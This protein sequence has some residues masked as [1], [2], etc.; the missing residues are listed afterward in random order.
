[1]SAVDI[2]PISDHFIFE[3]L[4]DTHEIMAANHNRNFTIFSVLK[5]I[6]YI[7]ALLANKL[8][9]DFRSPKKWTASLKWMPYLKM[10]GKK[11]S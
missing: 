7:Y 5:A 10:T 9:F 2:I 6:K 1:M 8:K 3:L 4:L 11:V